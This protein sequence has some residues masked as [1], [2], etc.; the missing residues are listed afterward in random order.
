MYEGQGE[1]PDPFGQQMVPVKKGGQGQGKQNAVAVQGKNYL[2]NHG[3]ISTKGGPSAYDLYCTPHQYVKVKAP[4][5][6]IGYK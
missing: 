3:I 6:R 5:K 4:M 1:H 2:G